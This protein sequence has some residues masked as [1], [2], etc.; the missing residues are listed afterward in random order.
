M[1]EI[2]VNENEAG[3]RFD[4]L[5]AKYLNEAP[6]SFLYKMLRKKNIVLNDKKAV[7]NEK[8]VLG[9]RITLYLSAE[10]IQKFSSNKVHYIK[11][12]IN[13]IYEDTDILLINKPVG[14]LS[15]KAREQDV[16]VIEHLISYLLRTK[17]L[18][19]AQ[20]NGFKPS[21]SN[22]L[23]RNTSG[24]IVAGKSLQGLQVMGE[25][26][27]NRSIQKFYRCLVLGHIDKKTHVK[28]YLRKDERRNKVYITEERTENSQWIETEYQPIW[29][30]KDITLLEVHLIT[31]KTH[32]IRAHLS[33]NGHAIIGDY[34][35]GNAVVNNIYKK[36]YGLESQLLH[37]YRL[38]MPSDMPK[39]KALEGKTF[40]AEVPELFARI[41]KAEKGV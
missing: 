30:T 9:D 40:I 22:R 38:E 26:F 13:I 27:K 10:T 17:Q 41:C 36:N 1:Q 16:S 6:K 31:G 15:Q 23:D 24:L 39:L 37:A 25:A 7:G 18:T 21:I 3:Q 29:S 28:G 12:N 34:K 19:E 8:V 33:A 20:L 2:L 14:M 4:K 11:D 5:L 32:Q 35:Y